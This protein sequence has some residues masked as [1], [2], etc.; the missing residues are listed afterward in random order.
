MET[1]KP[2]N[3]TYAAN[4]DFWQ[5]GKPAV[6]K[7]EYPAYTD[8]SPANQD[9]ANGKAQWGGQFIPNV[10]RYYVN[11]DKENNHF[12]YP[13]T[14]NVFL[15]FNLKHDDHRQEGD[16]AG[17]RLRDRPRIGVEDR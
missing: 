16:P 17:L 14:S 8:N 13:P 1:C 9:L 15:Q 4:P 10:E 2:A 11:R 12:W 7:V 5:P 3:I 6:K